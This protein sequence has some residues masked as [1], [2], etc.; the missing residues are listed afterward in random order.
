MEKA[1][2][3]NIIELARKHHDRREAVLFS[4][5]LAK[6]IKFE[7]DQIIREQS[8]KEACRIF[9]FNFSGVQYTDHA[10]LEELVVG[11]QVDFLRKDDLLL[12]CDGMNEEVSEMLEAAVVVYNYKMQKQKALDNHELAAMPKDDDT[13]K[14]LILASSDGRSAYYGDLEPKLVM[15]YDYVRKFGRV[16]ARGLAEYKN[17]TINNASL[18]LKRLYNLRL[19]LRDKDTDYVYGRQH[20]YWLPEELL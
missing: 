12:Y 5:H 10:F 8:E 18:W 17:V 6:S 7:T 14:V 11:T 16:T 15:T 3:I 9:K 19:V 2:R 1:Y 4:R 13:I 20:V